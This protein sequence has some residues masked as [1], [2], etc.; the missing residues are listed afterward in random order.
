MDTCKNCRWNVHGNC[1]PKM[2]KH[3]NEKIAFE[4]P[5]Y[6]YFAENA[7]DD[8]DYFCALHA[9]RKDTVM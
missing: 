3:F 6:P 5:K 1:E 7:I 9:P 8:E 4:V 2:P